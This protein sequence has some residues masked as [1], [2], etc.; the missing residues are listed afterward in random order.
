MDPAQLQ[1]QHNSLK[2]CPTKITH[3]DGSVVVLNDGVETKQPQTAAGFVEDTSPD[4]IAVEIVPHVFLGSQDCVMDKEYLYRLGIK[5]I[6]CVAPMIE[7][8]FPEEFE[9][10]TIPLLDLPTYN[11]GENIHACIECIHTAVSTNENVLCHCN[12]GI[13]RSPA[14]IIAYLIKYMDMT[15]SDAY[16][17]VLKKRP[18]AH[19]NGGFQRYLRCEFEPVERKH[20]KE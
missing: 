7:P 13:S 14:V 10:I 9:Y 5:K 12:A 15:F 6:L 1:K 20:N 4:N 16:N 8:L 17:Q 2:R 19:P 11:L 3:V 18:K